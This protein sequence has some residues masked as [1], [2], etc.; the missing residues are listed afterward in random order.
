V[1]THPLV[2]FRDVQWEKDRLIVR[3]PKTEQHKGH[4][5]RI[6]PIVPKLMSLLQD[7]REAL[8]DGASDLIVTIRG[9]GHLHDG[10]HRIIKRAQVEPWPRLW[11]TLRSSCEKEWR[12][13]SRSMRSA[14]GSATA[15][16]S[17]GSTMPTAC[18]TNSSS[19]PR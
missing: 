13:G 4:D 16:L 17:A 9:H 8:P 14:G 6:V 15:S 1:S 10:L 3:S 7:A 18:R 11:Q 19:G 12:C 5:Q 2:T